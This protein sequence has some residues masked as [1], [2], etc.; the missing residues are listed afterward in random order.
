LKEYKILLLGCGG[1]LT[2]FGGY[3]M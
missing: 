2:I 1:A 3:F